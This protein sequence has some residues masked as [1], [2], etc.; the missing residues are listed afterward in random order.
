MYVY[1]IYMKMKYS[2]RMC[3]CTRVCVR[4]CVCPCMPAWIVHGVEVAAGVSQLRFH[5]MTH[6]DGKVL[7]TTVR[8]NQIDVQLPG[9][10]NQGLESTCRLR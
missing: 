10:S 8:P 3:K 7:A 1:I 2:P 9:T 6:I 5:A 4:L